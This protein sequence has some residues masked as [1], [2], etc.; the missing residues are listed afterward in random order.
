ML[1]E[2]SLPEADFDIIIKLCLSENKV[3]AYINPAALASLLWDFWWLAVRS[4]KGEDISLSNEG[5][6][7]D[8]PECSTLG[9]CEITMVGEGPV[10]DHLH[11]PV[12]EYR[13]TMASGQRVRVDLYVNRLQA[14]QGY[15]AL[16]CLSGMD[17]SERMTR[18]ELFGKLMFYLV[19]I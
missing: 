13:E 8:I 1:E 16:K 18:V 11:N 17:T 5:E 4:S 12:A 7:R 2:P 19:A 10:M 14:E 6:L 9:Y 3:V 15:Q